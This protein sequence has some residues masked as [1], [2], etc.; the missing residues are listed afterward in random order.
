MNKIL[1]I[2]L[3]LLWSFNSN[4]EEIVTAN[5]Y[6]KPYSSEGFGED[7][8]ELEGLVKKWNKAHNER[9]LYTFSDLYADDVLLYGEANNKDKCI[10]KKM[11]YL[12]AKPDYYQQIKG[13]ISIQQ[14]GE[15][16]KCS[17]V[18]SVT[19]NQKTKDYPSYLIF[20]KMKDEWRIVVESD[21]VTDNNLA[22]RATKQ[23]HPKKTNTKN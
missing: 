9:G 13:T 18:K 3:L 22:K 14:N 12:K 7:N 1:Y 21:L 23:Q 6:N 16:A 17:F 4:A 8:Q 11:A 5:I 2:L 20:Q 19:I 10:D 15:R